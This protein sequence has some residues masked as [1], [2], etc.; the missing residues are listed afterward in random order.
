MEA[1][2]VGDDPYNDVAA[3]RSVG[4]DSVWVNRRA[5]S[6]PEDLAAPLYEISELGPLAVMLN[7]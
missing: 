5:Q 6:W 4:M 7:A 1:L 2:H 3:P